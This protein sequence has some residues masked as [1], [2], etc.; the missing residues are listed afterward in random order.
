MSEQFP[1]ADQLMA[2]LR[3]ESQLMK[4]IT[5]GCIELRWAVSADEQ[6]MARAIV[7]NAFETYAI[8]RGMSLPQAEQFCEQHLEA[9]IRSVWDAIDR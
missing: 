5:R 6:D 3:R 1:V 7:Y 4:L 8:E 2:D 9:L